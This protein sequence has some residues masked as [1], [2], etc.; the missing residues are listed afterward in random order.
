MQLKAHYNNTCFY[1]A[2][3]GPPL[4][5]KEEK[6]NK[7]KYVLFHWC[8][9]TVTKTSYEALQKAASTLNIL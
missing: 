4:S 7:E 9:C 8:A 1:V 3:L 5:K 2:C 6:T